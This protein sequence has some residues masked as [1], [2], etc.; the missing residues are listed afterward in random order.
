M[1]S[2]NTN[3]ENRSRKSFLNAVPLPT[4][5]RGLANKFVVLTAIKRKAQRV[6]GYTEGPERKPVMQRLQKTNW[7]PI[8]PKLILSNPGSDPVQLGKP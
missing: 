5:G 1:C 2:S 4:P 7:L 3:R 8:N 6:A